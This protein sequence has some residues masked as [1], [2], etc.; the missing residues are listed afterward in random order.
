MAFTVTELDPTTWESI[1]ELVERNN[2]IFGGCGRRCV[3]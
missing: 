3:K 2:G 1:A